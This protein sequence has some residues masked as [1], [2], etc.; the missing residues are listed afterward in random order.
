MEITM[1]KDVVSSQIQGLS[2]IASA[3]IPNYNPGAVMKRI[4]LLLCCA[5]LAGAPALAQVPGV[6]LGFGVHGNATNFNV[7]TS[8]GDLQQVYGLGIGGG[9]HLDLAIPL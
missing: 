4:A 6:S 9:I 2:H 5:L 7:G 8:Y 1:L 3:L